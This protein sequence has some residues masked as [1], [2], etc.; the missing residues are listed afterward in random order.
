MERVREQM[1]TDDG[2]AELEARCDDLSGRLAA[3][4][5]EKERYVKLYAR[6]HLSDEELD[7]HLADLRTATENLSL[8]LEA[9]RDELAERRA[10]ATLADSAEAWLLRLRESVSEVE[11][12]SEDA[13]LARHPLVRLL[14]ASIT[15][16]R[17]PGGQPEVRVTYRFGE[18]PAETEET[19]GFVSFEENGKAFEV[20][21]PGEA[22][23]TFDSFECAIHALAPT[24]EHCGCK[25]I[26]HGVEADGHF[27]CCAHC[28]SMAGTEGVADRA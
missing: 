28:A 12:D 18:P 2:A 21:L 15:V 24:C 4:R 17:A 22:A 19:E 16:G 26:G 13:Y 20:T 6:G 9:A 1:E 10:R 25:V 8:L 7:L 3:K 14:V 27:Y 11:R 5:S 23:R